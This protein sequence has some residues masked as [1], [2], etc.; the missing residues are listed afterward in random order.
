MGLDISAYRKLS[1]APD[2]AME[3]GC[4][5]E[6]DKYAQFHQSSLDWTKEHWPHH[7]DGIQAGVYSFAEKI[8]FR[9]GS[10]SGYN[11]WRR[12]L[13]QFAFGKPVEEVWESNEP[14]PFIELIHFAD[15]EGV[16]GPTVAAK[17]AKD[18]AEHQER[19]EQ[20]AA[21][22]PDGDYWLAKYKDWRKAFD[23]AADNGAVDFH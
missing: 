11:S 18:F 2:A 10:Y 16:I 8:G 4:V 19:A 21:T 13:A 15:N 23:I 20:Y 9:A 14:G 17:L 6:W 7:A 5:V 12:K 22:I 1:P 3:D